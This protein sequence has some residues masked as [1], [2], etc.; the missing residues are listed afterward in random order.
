MQLQRVLKN[1][2]HP[3]NYMEIMFLKLVSQIAL[4]LMVN[5][6]LMILFQELVSSYVQLHK[7]YMGTL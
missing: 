2:L 4:Q 3:H 5:C 6:D 1:V 7:I